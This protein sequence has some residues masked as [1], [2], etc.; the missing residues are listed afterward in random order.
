MIIVELTAF[1]SF[2][3]FYIFPFFFLL[4]EKFFPTIEFT[5]EDAAEMV[6][7][8]KA[9]SFVG[10]KISKSRD[11]HGGNVALASLPPIRPSLSAEDQ[12]RLMRA[13]A[14]TATMNGDGNDDSSSSEL[15]INA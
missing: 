6:C 3:E 15:P 10:Y 11:S 1:F 8:M 14:S 7:V 2:N 9:G 4:I 5:E 12:K 13:A